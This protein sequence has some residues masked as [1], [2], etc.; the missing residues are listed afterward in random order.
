MT[1]FETLSTKKLT[2]LLDTETPENV[3][4]I[5]AVLAKRNGIKKQA[6]PAAYT[7]EPSELT[8]AEQKIIDDLEAKGETAEEAPV[9]K[10]TT[11]SLPECEALAATLQ[12]KVGCKCEILP[13][14]EIEWVAGVVTGV[15]I[16]KRSNK[17]LFIVKGD[18]GKRMLKAH[19]AKGI[20][21][22][23]EKTEITRKAFG[24][25]VSTVKKLSDAEL[26]Q[27]VA[28]AKEHVGQYVEVV[29]FGGDTTVK[30]LI[31]GIVPEKR[32]N[33]V[34][35]R[36]ELP[37]TEIEV[38][39]K[40]EVTAGKTIH[41][42]FGSSEITYLEEWDE[43]RKEAYAKRGSAVKENLSPA[44]KAKV[45]A[46]KIAKMEADI[47]KKNASL[48]LLKQELAGVEEAALAETATTEAAPEV[49]ADEDAD[50]M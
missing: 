42:V 40:I 43:A 32:V 29:P 18:N 46:D 12:A 23:E 24:R 14:N 17:V 27:A 31:I 39:G 35:L 10:T 22:G 16:E 15:H 49:A 30:A 2:A 11:M 4:L 44:E 19:D 38:D 5:N 34:L 8:E 9:V 48:D 36:I 28:E 25:T 45:L 21:I 33:K 6:D 41:K 1:N 47:A 20:R 7:M 50:L 37:G 13:F 3:E 26:E